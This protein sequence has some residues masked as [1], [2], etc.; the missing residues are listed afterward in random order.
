MPVVNVKALHKSTWK[1]FQ[2]YIAFVLGE[3]RIKLI[4]YSTHVTTNAVHFGK[5]WSKLL[6]ITVSIKAQ[7]DKKPLI[8]AICTE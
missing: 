2:A 4:Y 3:K 7:A 6:E 8:V 1:I 5:T